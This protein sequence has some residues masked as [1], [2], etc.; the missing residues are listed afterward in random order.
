MS[1]IVRADDGFHWAWLYPKHW[2]AWFTCAMI[3]VF[4]LMPWGIQRRLGSA[5][6]W[7]A[8]H[9]AHGRVEDTRTNLRLCF[10]ERS[11]AEREAM[12]RDVFHHAGIGIFEIASSWFKPLARMNK[13]VKVIG[14]EHIK[15]AAETGRGVIILG[16]HYSMLDLNGVMAAIHFPL[17]VVYRP[18]NNPILDYF[19]RS[20]RGR[21][22]Y[23]Q[24]DHDDM[25]SLFKALKRGEI[26]WTAVDQDFGLKQGVMAP[27]FGQPAATLSVTARMAR[28]NH[29]AVVFVHFMRNPDD[30]TY[31]LLFTPPLQNYPSGDDAVDAARINIEVQHMIERA[32]T[33]YMW[34]H[35]R[36]KTQPPGTETVYRKRVRKW[37]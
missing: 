35:R 28:I 37:S 10:P 32:P 36:F 23:G 1:R 31:T 33:Q 4:G 15:Q 14:L 17:H 8:Y 24:I 3:A 16:A 13:R 2:G 27:F 6:G 18:Q 30:Q 12:T 34:F 19:V 26:L 22:H 11:E 9:L 29:S 20:C 5:I 7:L 25:R 21:I